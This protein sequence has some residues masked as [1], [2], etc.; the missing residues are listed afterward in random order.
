MKL[1]INIPTSLADIK[2]SDYQRLQKVIKE[3]SDD[4]DFVNDKA[5]EILCKVPYEY[6]SKIKRADYKFAIAT[7]NDLINKLN[8]DNQSEITEL[9]PTFSLNNSLF[10]FVPDL[11]ESSQGEYFDASSYMTDWETMHKAMAVLFRK[12]TMKKGDLY[13]IEPYEGSFKY[14]ETFLDMR[15][16]VVNSAIVFF[17]NLSNDLLR[18]MK[19]FMSKILMKDKQAMIT[20]QRSGVDMHQF[21]A[22]LEATSLN[23]K[24]Q[25]KLISMPLLR[26]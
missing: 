10:G 2:L 6:V 15:M 8:E 3:N 16:N 23:L 7:I 21:M 20:L 19:A 17:Y 12:V 18:N 11:D 13:N 24:N 25:L 4:N 22:S 14:A 5:I 26:S 9:I 1:E